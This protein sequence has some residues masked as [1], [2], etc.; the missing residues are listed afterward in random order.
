M[1]LTGTMESKI[2]VQRLL[3]PDKLRLCV[4]LMVISTKKASEALEA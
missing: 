1:Y 3:I 2:F 4:A